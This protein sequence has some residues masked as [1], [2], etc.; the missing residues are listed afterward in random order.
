[1]AVEQ[2]SYSETPEFHSPPI[3]SKYRILESLTFTGSAMLR[4]PTQEGIPGVVSDV[5]WVDGIPV[6]CPVGVAVGA[7][8]RDVDGE[9]VTG[10]IVGAEGSAVGVRVGFRV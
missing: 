4:P 1:M 3:S 2:F 7:L 6:G 9:L 8:G 5:W 10:W